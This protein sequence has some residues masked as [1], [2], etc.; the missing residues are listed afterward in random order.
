MSSFLCDSVSLWNAWYWGN[1]EWICSWG[2]LVCLNWWHLA[3]CWNDQSLILGGSPGRIS[4]LYVSRQQLGTVLCFWHTT[5]VTWKNDLFK[6][7]VFPGIPKH[8]IVNKCIAVR[9]QSTILP[10]KFWDS[11]HSTIHLEKMHGVHAYLPA[12]W[13]GESTCLWWRAFPHIPHISQK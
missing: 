8:V 9:K 7:T 6:V 2:S 1:S 3:A 4:K 11:R 12:F 13:D 5:V 10:L